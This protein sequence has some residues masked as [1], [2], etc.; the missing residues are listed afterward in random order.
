M[1]NRKSLQWAIVPILLVGALLRWSAIG[2]MSNMLHYD[3]AHN[4]LDVL[5]LIQNP[6]LT[7]FMPANFGRESLWFYILLPFVAI[8]GAQPFALRLAATM[9]GI[10]TLAALYQLGKKVLPPRA[11]CWATLALAVCQWHVHLSRM[12]LRTILLPLIGVL[13]FWS[14]FQACQTDRRSHWALAGVWTGLLLY[15]YF[16]SLLWGWFIFFRE[17]C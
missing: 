13:A 9:T 14:L 7:P 1:G 2:P 17:I 11:A 16:S 5:S 6:R 10:L 8:W 3:E 12:A 4:G 15:T